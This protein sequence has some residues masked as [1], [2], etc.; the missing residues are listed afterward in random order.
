MCDAGRRQWF[1]D[2]PG[3][4]V[5]DG[6]LLNLLGQ[7]PFFVVQSAVDVLEF[8][9]HGLVQLRFGDFV[10]RPGHDRTGVDDSRQRG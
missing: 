6:P 4:K 3:R 5:L 8:L 1:S 2:L 9:R 7:P 10:G